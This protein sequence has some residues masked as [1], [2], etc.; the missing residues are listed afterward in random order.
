MP[1]TVHQ[2]LLLCFLITV[3][4]VLGFL[5]SYHLTD[6]TA[7][8]NRELLK[9]LKISILFCV[10]VF[11]A[12]VPKEKTDRAR[13]KIGEGRPFASYLLAAVVAALLTQCIN[14]MFDA[15]VQKSSVS[16]WVTLASRYP[17]MILPAAL[18]GITAALCD[19]K[20]WIR[21]DARAQRIIE[22]LSGG[23]S[24]AVFACLTYWLLVAVNSKSGYDIPSAGFVVGLA[25]SIGLVVA[26]LVPSWYRE[27]PRSP[28]PDEIKPQLRLKLLSGHL[29]FRI[30]RRGADMVNIYIKREGEPAVSL[31]GENIAGTIWECETSPAKAKS[32]YFARGLIGGQEVGELSDAVVG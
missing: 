6:P 30:I 10:A 24:M 8:I 14:I 23:M 2:L 4:M 18:T 29:R 3:I 19:N 9:A 15:L 20:P 25:S 26:F 22:G 27:A 13:R 7:D 12:V 28:D 31:A 1:F 16:A 32:E 21:F 11:C 5:G 17:W